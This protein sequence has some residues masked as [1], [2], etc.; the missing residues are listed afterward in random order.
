MIKAAQDGPHSGTQLTMLRSAALLRRL[1]PVNLQTRSPTQRLL[2]RPAVS[3]P[4]ASRALHTSVYLRNQ[5]SQDTPP[6]E[7]PPDFFIQALENTAKAPWLHLASRTDAESLQRLYVLTWQIFFYLSRPQTGE[8][9]SSDQYLLVSTPAI[10]VVHCR[11]TFRINIAGLH[12]GR[13]TSGLRDV[14]SSPRCDFHPQSCSHQH[15]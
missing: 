13:C 6:P 12:P 5:S 14:P 7:I 1:S 3:A 2:R 10:Y 8:D 15:Q 11:L 4:R 9:F